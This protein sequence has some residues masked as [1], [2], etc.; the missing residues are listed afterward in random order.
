MT[1]ELIQGDCLDIM[2]GMDDKSV[3]F[4]W[5]VPPYNVNGKTMG[6]TQT[7]LVMKIIL[8]FAADGLAKL[9]EYLTTK[10]PSI[11]QQ[12]TYWNIGIY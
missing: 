12:N 2:R 5:T 1:V 6:P 10:W 3:D 4:I 8:I 11:R 9:K 7:I